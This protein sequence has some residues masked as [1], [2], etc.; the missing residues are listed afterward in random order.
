MEKLVIWTGRGT[1]ARS[2]AELVEKI[3]RISRDLGREIASLDEARKIT[4]LNQQPVAA[5]A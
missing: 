5:N 2:N 3:A 1:L 4:G